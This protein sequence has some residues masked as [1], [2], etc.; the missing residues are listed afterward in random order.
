MS[1]KNFPQDIAKYLFKN[2]DKGLIGFR[3]LESE[4]HFYENYDTSSYFDL[5]E[6][7]DDVKFIMNLY[8]VADWDYQQ[9]WDD[10]LNKDG[11][12]KL[13]IFTLN[14]L[15]DNDKEY[16]NNKLGD[17]EYILEYNDDGIPDII[18]NKEGLSPEY[19]GYLL[20]ENKDKLPWGD[21]QFIPELPPKV[22][23]SWQKQYEEYSNLDKELS[24]EGMEEFA[25]ILDKIDDGSTEE[26][27]GP[28]DANELLNY[29]D[30][31]KEE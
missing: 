4:L 28:F 22:K 20:E 30:E 24:E 15:F 1:I 13:S 21:V 2:I 18:V 6:N 11:K 29:L 25:E 16:F 19:I 23:E 31:L 17:K 27:N 12:V 8:S 9:T 5:L 14:S 26:K 3:N 10:L 7:A